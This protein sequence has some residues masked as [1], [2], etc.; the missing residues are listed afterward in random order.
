M[1]SITFLFLINK[2][3]NQRE[4]ANPFVGLS[5]V[6]RLKYRCNRDLRDDEII[7]ESNRVN[8]LKAKNGNPIMQGL[9][10]NFTVDNI[11]HKNKSG[12]NIVKPYK[13]I[14]IAHNSSGFG[15]YIVMDS[16]YNKMTSLKLVKTDR[17]LLKLSFRSGF[18]N[19]IPQ[20][21]KIIRS[22]SHKSGSIAEIGREYGVR[23]ELLKSGMNPVEE[24][25][26]KNKDLERFWSP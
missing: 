9:K 26:E 25:K 18:I 2:T 24:N 21:I 15:S 3:H 1:N 10:K 4:Y 14:L 19:E 17:G 23:P 20:Y 7:T 16:L 8:K 12:T 13:I 11:I 22:K 6:S 5:D